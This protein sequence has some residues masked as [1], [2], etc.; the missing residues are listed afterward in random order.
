M[1]INIVLWGQ[2]LAFAIFWF[3]P[4]L[5]VAKNRNIKS[6]KKMLWIVAVVFLSWIAWILCTI[7]AP[8]SRADGK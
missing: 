6:D 3:L 4:I 5:L 2:S 8:V 1:N 7:F